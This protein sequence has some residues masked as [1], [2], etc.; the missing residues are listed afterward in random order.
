VEVLHRLDGGTELDIDMTVKDQAEEGIVGNHIAVV[1]RQSP[2]SEAP[3][4]V[5][6]LIVG[7]RVLAHCGVLTIRARVALGT[8][9]ILHTWSLWVALTTRS[10][11]HV[12]EHNP[13]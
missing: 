7:V 8:L 4:I 6:A 3:S 1:D 11:D 10:M 5:R 12:L 13:V 2:E 9:P